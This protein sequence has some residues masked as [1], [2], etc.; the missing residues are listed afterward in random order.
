MSEKENKETTM[1]EEEV[2]L[3]ESTEQASTEELVEDD[4]VIDSAEETDAVQDAEETE[5][6]TMTEA[7]DA[8]VEVKPGDIVEGTVLTIDEDKNVIVGLDTGHE[9]YIPIR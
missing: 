8:S 7:L 3:E 6:E 4:V 2:T 5:V 9:G 1:N